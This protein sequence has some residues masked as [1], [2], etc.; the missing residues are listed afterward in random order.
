[1]EKTLDSLVQQGYTAEI[2]DTFGCSTL[3]RFS[4]RLY[5]FCIGGKV[6]SA[7]LVKKIEIKEKNHCV[8]HLKG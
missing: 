6:F 3:R 5:I 7:D 1:M 2:P 8:I 4:D